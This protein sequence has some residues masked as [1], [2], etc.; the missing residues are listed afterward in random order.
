MSQKAGKAFDLAETKAKA[1]AVKKGMK[2]N[3][4]PLEELVM[5]KSESQA[6]WDKWAQDMEAKGL[7]GK[8]VLVEAMNLLGHRKAK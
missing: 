8:A 2:A 7:P 6:V 3:T 4:L 5:W 1:I